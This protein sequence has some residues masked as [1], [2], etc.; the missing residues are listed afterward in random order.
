M[1]PLYQQ[2]LAMAQIAATLVGKGNSLDWSIDIASELWKKICVKTEPEPK[3]RCDMKGPCINYPGC[4][5][6]IGKVIP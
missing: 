6:S 3:K 1:D 2:R 5:C 4:D